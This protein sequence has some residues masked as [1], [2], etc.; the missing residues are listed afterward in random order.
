ML[1]LCMGIAMPVLYIEIHVLVYTYTNEQ[2]LKHTR[3]T[4][5]SLLKWKIH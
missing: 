5:T 3:D 2:A 4:H 1:I